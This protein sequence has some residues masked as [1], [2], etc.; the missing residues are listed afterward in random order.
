VPR[1][2]AA[3]I[4]RPR[5]WLENRGGSLTDA[6]IQVQTYFACLLAGE[7]L[8]H[9]RDLL[10]RDYVLDTLDHADAIAAFPSYYPRVGFGPGQR[11]LAQGTYV[12]TLG[13]EGAEPTVTD[14]IWTAVGR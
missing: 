10:Y 6:R 13:G 9:V 12:L 4:A 2:R 5:T 11:H 3:A 14:A 8:M 7:V 1:E